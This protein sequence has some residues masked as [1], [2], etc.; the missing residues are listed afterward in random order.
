[1]G[2]NTRSLSYGLWMRLSSVGG[3]TVELCEVSK[4]SAGRNHGAATITKKVAADILKICVRWVNHD[5][6]EN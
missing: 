1:M 3:R 5:T 6:N 4:I 2:V